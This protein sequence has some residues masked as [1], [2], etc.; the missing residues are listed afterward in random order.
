MMQRVVL[1]TAGLCLLSGCGSAGP[2][3]GEVAG[4]VTL[5]EKPVSGAYVQFVPAKG[6]RPAGGLTDPQ[7]R[8]LLT[9]SATETGALVGPA[10]V[11]IT[12]G[13]PE[14]G[15][16]ESLPATYNSKTTLTVDVG[17]GKNTFDFPL[18][19]R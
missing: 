4:L 9:Y 15:V 14:G 6:G 8:Y 13:D 12:T 17:P 10:K 5:D 18:K 3:L 7:G 16:K 2:E 1:L 19:S 11:L